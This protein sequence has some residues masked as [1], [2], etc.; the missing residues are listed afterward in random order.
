MSQLRRRPKDAPPR[1]DRS[2]E[3]K[4][5]EPPRVQARMATGLDRQ[6]PSPVAALLA[7]M[8]ATNQPSSAAG[9][10][11][12]GRVAALGCRLCVRLGFGHTAC[13]VHHVRTGHGAA[14][15][16]S[17]FLTI[18]LCPDHHR[19]PRGVHGDKSALRLAKVTEMDLLADT[20]AALTG[21]AA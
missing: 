14:E 16:A 20:I 3:F 1:R 15:R 11:H 2:A 18:G 19:G 5:F 12:M 13:E 8:A 21:E 17:D 9:K 6:R 7:P 10:R 4:S